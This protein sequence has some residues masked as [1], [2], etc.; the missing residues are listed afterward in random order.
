MKAT[1]EDVAKLRERHVLARVGNN[2][3]MKATPEDVAKHNHSRRGYLRLPASM[4]ATPEDVA[5]PANNENQFGRELD[6][7]MKATPEDVAK[8]PA[9]RP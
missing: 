8:H 6:A 1:P 7:S 2:A 3:S 4:K 9:R 5:K